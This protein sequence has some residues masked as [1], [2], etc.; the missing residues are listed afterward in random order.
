MNYETNMEHLSFV[1]LQASSGITDEAITQEFSIQPSFLDEIKR[2]EKEAPAHLINSLTILADF[3]PDKKCLDIGSQPISD[4]QFDQKMS[5]QDFLHF[6]ESFDRIGRETE[7]FERNGLKYYV[8]DFWTSRQRQ[9]NRI[10][11]ISYR[12][13][14]KAELPSFFI[15]RLTDTGDS[16]FD[17]FMGRGTTLV[18]AAILNRRPVGNDINP[19]SKMLV[20]P[21]LDTPSFSKIIERLNA[22]ESDYTLS[23]EKTSNPDLLT[24]YHPETLDK[25][26]YLRDYFIDRTATGLID[27]VDSWIRMVCINRLTGHSSGFFSVYTL[28]PNQATS[29]KRQKKINEKRQQTPDSRDVFAII[30]KKTKSLLSAYDQNFHSSDYILS[31][32]SANDLATLKDDSV[33][34]IVTSPPFLDIV[35]YAQ[36]NWLRSWFAGFDIGGVEIAIHKKV[37]DWVGFVRSCFVEF[38]RTVKTGGFVAFEVGEVRNKSVLLE[39]CVAQAV[40]GLPFKLLGVMINDQKFSKTSNSWGVSNNSKGTNTNRIVLLERID[41]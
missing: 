3:Q 2:G 21:R 10:H 22:L 34:L 33:D 41:G 18:Q 6:L 17:P 20:E 5:G 32:G 37:E 23:D 25:I 26:E 14:F 12:A 27:N 4:T 38:S 29:V 9:S 16:V 28:P 15:E 13:C 35:D 19:L 31:T 7:I 1:D 24:F 36:D 40:E 11:E 39:E 8:N 30:L